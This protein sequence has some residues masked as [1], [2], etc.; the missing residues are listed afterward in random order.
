MH[1]HASPS[2]ARMMSALPGT[3]PINVCLNNA[4]PLIMSNGVD[5]LEMVCTSYESPGGGEHGGDD[6]DD[7]EE[8]QFDFCAPW[9]IGCGA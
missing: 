3:W 8:E 4:D 2:V 6:Q 5:M 9:G 7:S 1:P